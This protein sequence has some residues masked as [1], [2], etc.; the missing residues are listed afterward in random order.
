[1]N[2]FYTQSGDDGFTNLLGEG[3]VEKHHKRIEAVGTIDEA[4]AAIGLARRLSKHK[5]TDEILLTVQRD[6]YLM[7]SEIAST[8]ENAERFRIIGTK[9]VN[10]L[11]EITDELSKRIEIPKEFIIP[12]DTLAGAAV[13]IARTVVRRAERRV[14]QLFLTNELE[15]SQLLRYL[16]RLSSLCFILELHENQVEESLPPTLAKS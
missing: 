16:N 11:E 13:S 12:G 9:Q 1:M 3:R 5:N 4:S 2:K 6:L 14:S 7:M 15:N 8:P 10:W